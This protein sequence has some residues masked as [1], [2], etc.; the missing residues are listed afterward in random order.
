M[1]P[2]ARILVY[3]VLT[4]DINGTLN[5][6][7]YPLVFIYHTNVIGVSVFSFQF[8]DVAE[9]AIIQKLI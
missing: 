1:A 7:V 5:N 3:S 9:V 2:Y 6:T 8:C 4:K